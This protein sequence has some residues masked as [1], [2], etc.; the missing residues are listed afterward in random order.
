MYKQYVR[1]NNTAFLA[2]IPLTKCITMIELLDFLPYIL[3]FIAGFV[4]GLILGLL[5]K[6]KNKNKNQKKLKRDRM[7]DNVFIGY[8]ARQNC[9]G[10]DNTILGWQD[11][12]EK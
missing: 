6:N 5:N 11:C 10:S 4:L 8:T 12:E 1:G 7:S 2:V 9:T 3:S